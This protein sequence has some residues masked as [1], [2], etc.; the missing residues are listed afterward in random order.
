MITAT[1]EVH[2]AA[3]V[4]RPKSLCKTST[5]A[6]RAKN[7]AQNQ[8]DKSGIPLQDLYLAPHLPISKFSFYS[9]LRLARKKKKWLLIYIQSATMP[10]CR[11]L[12][13]ELWHHPEITDIV[14]RNFLFLPLNH[15]DERAKAYIGECYGD[16]AL[17][18]GREGRL[19]ARNNIELP[20]ICTVASLFGA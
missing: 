17:D 15:N 12:N 5:I 6:R 14:S 1:R 18:E 3:D 19:Y 13:R 20:H 10:T 16:L 4:I 7:D 11:V 8:R 9:A 2:I